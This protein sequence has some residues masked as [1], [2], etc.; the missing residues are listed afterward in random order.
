[1][2]LYVTPHRWTGY[3]SIASERRVIQLDQSK[4]DYKHQVLE[5]IHMPPWRIFLWVKFIEI[6]LQAR[7]KALWRSFFQRDRASRHGMGW[8]TRM[9]RR[10]LVHEW[11]NFWFRDCRVS[12]G[13]TLQEFWGAPQVHQEI[14]LFIHSQH[15]QKQQAKPAEATV[16]AN[17]LSD[18]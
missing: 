8:F 12:N 5:T 1:M 17:S 15:Q 16:T 2:S 14:P 3:Y 11:W 4:W 7:P 10:V 9:G 13:P 18:R 6:I